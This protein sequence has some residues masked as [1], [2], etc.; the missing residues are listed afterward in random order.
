MLRRVACL[1]VLLMG[2]KSDPPGDRDPAADAAPF[3]RPD[4]AVFQPRD[5]GP[6]GCLDQVP[7]DW[8][9]NGPLDESQFSFDGDFTYYADMVP[10]TE[11]FQRLFI[12]L[13]AD[14]GVFAGGAV[15][16]G[17][18]V[19]EGDEIDYSWCGACVYLAVDDDGSAPSVIYMA[20]TGKL[21]VDSVD[22]DI[23]G[24]LENADLTQID[25]T[26]SGPSCADWMEGD[27]WP[28]GNSACLGSTE[29]CEVQRL[30]PEC[31]TRFDSFT[32]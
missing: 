7:D 9:S 32:F 27:P 12:S 4:G 21:T 6:D 14:M 16:P 13:H 26:A 5:G 18:Y 28:C 17:T 25:L 8:G 10:D 15:E 3:D 24:T 31:T 23:H 20:Q 1:L 2:C 11:R 19:L 30:V 29:L 22:T